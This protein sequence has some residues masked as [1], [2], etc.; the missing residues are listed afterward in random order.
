MG[1]R[2]GDL[3]LLRRGPR[4]GATFSCVALSP[5][6][7]P[8]GPT[9]A[10]LIDAEVA[11]GRPRALHALRPCL[12]MV[13]RRRPLNRLASSRTVALIVPPSH[14]V[15]G[16]LMGLGRPF[17]FVRDTT[18]DLQMVAF[19]ELTPTGHVLAIRLA[20]PPCFLRVAAAL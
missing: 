14:V 19:P 2:R 9:L 17:T 20:V 1:C 7:R 18:G 10:S 11:K 13:D 3:R 6:R 8:F 12:V 15:F 16:Q 4:F 5:Q